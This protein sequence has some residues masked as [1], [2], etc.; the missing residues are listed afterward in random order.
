[1]LETMV[2]GVRDLTYSDAKIFEKLFAQLAS[3]E[4]QGAARPFWAASSAMLDQE[5]SRREAGG[6][7]AAGTLKFDYGGLLDADVNRLVNLLHHWLNDCIVR[8]ER[9]PAALL[10]WLARRVCEQKVGRVK[11]LQELNRWTNRNCLN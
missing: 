6:E 3:R 2:E 1:M 9:G 5:L 10:A 4:D 8:G 11:V 7:P